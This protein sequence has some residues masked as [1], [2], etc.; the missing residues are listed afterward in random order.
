MAGSLR[1]RVVGFFAPPLQ[2][3]PA[4]PHTGAYKSDRSVGDV[5]FVDYMYYNAVGSDLRAGVPVK[6]FLASGAVA[7]RNGR[8]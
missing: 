5:N 7:R 6:H 2:V 8:P 3:S 1:F 4:T